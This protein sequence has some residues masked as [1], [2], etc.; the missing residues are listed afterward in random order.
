MP[1][2]LR[3]TLAFLRELRDNNSKAWFERNRA[4]YTEARSAFES[5]I[6]DL[7]ARFDAVDDL[8]DVTTKECVSRMNRD[9]RFSRDKSPYAVSM[10]AVLA[11]GGR[12]HAGRSYYIHIQPDDNSLIGGGSYAPTPQELDQLRAAIAADSRE[13]RRIISED[14]FIRYF[15]GL[16]GEALKTA[17]QGY[18]KTHPAI[19]LLRLKQFLAGHT[20]SDAQVLADDAVSMALDVCA[21]LKPFLT[22]L[23]TTV[24]APATVLDRG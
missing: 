13:L 3:T 6:T 18:P 22:Y 11:R 16:S 12:K 19:D 4:Q 8:G 7:I 24:G 21:A 14:R 9:I 2:N 17:P 20:M 1:E 10:S 15:G 5:F 23:Q